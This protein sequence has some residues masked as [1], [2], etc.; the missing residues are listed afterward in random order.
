METQKR[1]DRFLPHLFGEI[2]PPAPTMESDGEK[3]SDQQPDPHEEA[4]SS[5]TDDQDKT[6]KDHGDTDD[7]DANDERTSTEKSSAS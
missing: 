1:L 5:K 3:Q 2:F 6:A 7:G 4:A